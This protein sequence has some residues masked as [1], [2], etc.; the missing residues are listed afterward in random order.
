MSTYFH[1]QTTYPRNYQDSQKTL[2][3]KIENFNQIP[4]LTVPMLES[5]EIPIQ[6]TS[7]HCVKRFLQENTESKHINTIFKFLVMIGDHPD[8]AKLLIW[9]QPRNMILK[10]LYYGRE[11]TLDTILRCGYKPSNDEIKQYKEMV[12]LNQIKKAFRFEPV[13]SKFY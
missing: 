3:H 10:C 9:E 8:V 4:K 13:I 11:D 7:L 2:L 5:K 1:Y 6:V 12:R